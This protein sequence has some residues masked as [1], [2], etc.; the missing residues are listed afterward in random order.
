MS[1]T[2]QDVFK[3]AM[4]LM[5]EESEDGT[6]EG[7]PTEYKRKAWSLITM[8]QTELLPPSYTPLAVTY[9]ENVLQLDDRVSITTLPYGIAAH[10][11]MNEDQNK[12][13]FFNARYDELKRK[14]PAFAMNI[15]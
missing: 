12:A 15:A 8:L 10:L 13:A 14:Q 11:L 2:A 6:F 9:E 3:L 5:D 4:D 1:V 7:Y